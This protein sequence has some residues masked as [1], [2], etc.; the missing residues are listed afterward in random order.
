MRLMQSVERVEK[1]L[2]NSFFSGKELN[3][4]NQKNIG[5]PVLFAKTDKLVVLNA[6]NVLI[7]KFFR[8]DKRHPRVFLMRGDMLADGVEKMGFS[9]THTAIKKKRIVRFSRGLRDGHRSGVGK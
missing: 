8:R 3:V 7:G 5:L 2:L 1:L 6:V 4:V 9:Q